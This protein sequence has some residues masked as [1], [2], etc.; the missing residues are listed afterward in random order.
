M[1]KVWTEIREFNLL[2]TLAKSAAAFSPPRVQIDP[3]PEL[4]FAP[5]ADEKSGLYNPSI[6]RQASV[7]RRTTVRMRFQ[8]SLPYGR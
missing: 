1:S 2:R 4:A 3:R 5:F 6:A 8:S 7:N